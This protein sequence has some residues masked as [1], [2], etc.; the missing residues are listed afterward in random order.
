M[1]GAREIVNQAFN[2]LIESYNSA[3][4]AHGLAITARLSKLYRSQV[5]I[6]R[7]EAVGKDRLDDKIIANYIHEISDR[8]VVSFGCG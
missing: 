8:R 5:I 4:A 1:S 2:D 3:L 7:H 6:R